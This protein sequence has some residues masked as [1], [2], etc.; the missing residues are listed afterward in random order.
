M[1]GEEPDSRMRSSMGTGVGP[2]R[3]MMRARLLLSGGA[4]G[5][6][7]DC[8]SSAGSSIWMTEDRA[9]RIDH[10]GGLGDHGR[11][12]LEQVV[13]PLCARIERRT[14]HREDFTALLERETGSDEGA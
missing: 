9:Q 10:V 13:A 1:A 2:S 12:L 8:G 14:G 7:G 5:G 3:P 11:A 4:C 6:Q